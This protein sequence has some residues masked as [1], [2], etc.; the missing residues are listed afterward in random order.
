MH[1]IL[2]DWVVFFLFFLEERCTTSQVLT[3]QMKPLLLTY[4]ICQYCYTSS[5]E[6]LNQQDIYLH[7]YGRLLKIPHVQFQKVDMLIIKTSQ[8]C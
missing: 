2:R 8:L 4:S 1:Y 3:Q 7:E 6:R 5:G